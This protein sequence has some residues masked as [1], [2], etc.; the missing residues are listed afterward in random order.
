MQV[1]A[2]PGRLQAWHVPPQ[3][4]PQQTPSTHWPEAHSAAEA[5]PSPLARRGVQVP[6]LQK[7]V[8]LQSA[9][10]AHPDRQL[11]P[12]PLHQVA[13]HSE[14][15]SL[16]AAWGEQVP[17]FPA[18]LQASQVP[19]QPPLQQT[20]S[21]HE[22]VAHSPAAVQASPAALR[23][24]HAPAAQYS[25]GLHWLSRVQVTVQPALAQYV[26]PHSF[27]GSVPGSQA[28]QVPTEPRTAHEAHLPVQAVSQQTPSTHWPVAHSLAAAQATPR[29]RFTAQLPLRQNA[30]EGQLASPVQGWGQSSSEPLQV[31]GEQV[32][33]PCEPEATGRQLPAVPTPSQRSHAPAQAEVQHTPSAQAEVT[34]SSAEAHVSPFALS[35]TQAEDRQ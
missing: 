4:L 16:A 33:L 18:R 10:S 17:S 8:S 35:G 15:G 5:Q 27:S 21:T 19:A 14:V 22:A 34:H 3:A 26:P 30:P 12:V 23:A 9:L 32:G 31:S 7:A 24:L 1:P 11:A 29:A 6:A 28:V 2:L 25:P 20:P 13:P